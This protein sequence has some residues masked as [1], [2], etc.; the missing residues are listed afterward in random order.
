M[1]EGSEQEL[2]VGQLATISDEALDKAY[3][4]GRSTPGNS[5]GWQANLMSAANAKMMIDAGVTDIEKISDAIHKGWNVTAQKFVQNPDQF[6]D[7]EKL[8][9]AG[10]LEAKL[11]QR[12]KL[13]KIDY[14]E[15]DNEEKEKDRVVARALLQAIKGQQGV[16]E[17]KRIARKAGQPANSKKHSD[18]YTDEN[19]K[20][21]IHGL[22]FATA[23]DARASVNKIKNSGRSHA[24]KVQAAVAMEQRAKAAGKKEAAAVYRRYINS[25]KKTDENLAVEISEGPVW[26]KV[27]RTAAAGAIATGLGYAAL[28]GQ[29]VDKTAS[30]NEP[31]TKTQTAKIN[32]PTKAELNPEPSKA[33]T[34]TKA[35]PK[36]QNMLFGHAVKAGLKG[37]E[38]AQF[39][40][41]SAHE[42]IGFTELS[43]L[44][45]KEYFRQYDL[46]FNPEKAKSL[47]NVKPGDG[48]RYKGRGFL[49]ITGRDNYRKAGKAIG[50]PLEK[51]PELAERPDVAAKI[52]VW[53]WKSRVRPGIDNWNDTIG[54]TQKI[55]PGM[56]GLGDR[57]ANFHKYADIFMSASR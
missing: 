13:M 18:L 28:T 53:F 39:M 16:A 48:E 12:A 33:S 52:A 19:P 38:L 7:T 1:T 43:E 32:E 30:V 24:H 3:G 9:Q 11:A 42:T 10:K 44:G 23:E 40:A 54:V 50:L 47:G 4:Y 37:A 14:I 22:K 46:N 29:G 17:G 15:L 8:R 55:N 57:D 5:F 27:K 56:Q 20:G 31:S 49:Q 35:D 34:M 2:S 51:R 41:Q 21:T 6:G 25:V 45:S 36:M 26:D